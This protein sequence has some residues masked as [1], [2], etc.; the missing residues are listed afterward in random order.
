M[1][2]ERGGGPG[3]W[4]TRCSGA[5][6][7][8]CGAGRLPWRLTRLGMLCFKFRVFASSPLDS[9]RASLATFRARVPGMST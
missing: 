4:S 5:A 6:R 9:P 2:L 7:G 3:L 1:V 8:P